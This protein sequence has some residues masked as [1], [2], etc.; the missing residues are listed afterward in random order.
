MCLGREFVYF[1]KFFEEMSIF[2]CFI[3]I[4]DFSSI[5]LSF[6]HKSFFTRFWRGLIE[7]IIN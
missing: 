5:L 3:A 7:F 4:I 2:M 1:S 6:I